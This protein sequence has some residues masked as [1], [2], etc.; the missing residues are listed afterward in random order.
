MQTELNANTMS[1]PSDITTFGL[2]V[3]SMHLTDYA[4]RLPDTALHLPVNPDSG[5][6][7]AHRE[8]APSIIQAHLTYKVEKVQYDTYHA[9]DRALKI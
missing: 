9:T 5:P 4:I 1:V 3:L 6:T 7:I 2:L 8:T